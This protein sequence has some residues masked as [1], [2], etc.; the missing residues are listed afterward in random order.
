MA[1]EQRD[2]FLP[3]YLYVIIAHIGVDISPAYRIIRRPSIRYF[4]DRDG[5]DCG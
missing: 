4:T 2:F 5:Q 1:R 3:P